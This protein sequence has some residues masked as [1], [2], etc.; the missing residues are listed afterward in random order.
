M[1]LVGGTTN[2]GGNR[3][4]NIAV[5]NAPSLKGL[6]VFGQSFIADFFA[7]N[8]GAVSSNA[9][10][11]TIGVR[12]QSTLIRQT[13]VLPTTGGITKNWAPVTLLEWEK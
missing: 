13:G 2:L 5:P 10:S 11:V 4:D 12:P 3:N 9:A 7:N 1:A 6:E 8:L